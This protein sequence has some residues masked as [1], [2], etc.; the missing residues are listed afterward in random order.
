MS[1]QRFYVYANF[2]QTPLPHGVMSVAV[3]DS[4]RELKA[5]FKEKEDANKYIVDKNDEALGE[6]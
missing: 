6:L 4:S 2:G 5:M 3:D 1:N